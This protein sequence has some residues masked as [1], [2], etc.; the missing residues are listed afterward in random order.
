MNVIIVTVITGAMASILMILPVLL[1]KRKGSGSIYG[2]AGF[3]V[4]VSYIFGH[5]QLTG[6]PPVFEK[7]LNMPT[8]HWTVVIAAVSILP[9]LAVEYAFRGDFLKYFMRSLFIASGLYAVLQIPYIA[10]SWPFWK[11]IAAVGGMSILAAIIWFEGETTVLKGDNRITFPL[12]VT[13]P[14]VSTAVIGLSG[15]FE[16]AILGGLVTA[17]S[18]G[19]VV[20]LL[21]LGLFK[22]EK[23]R[24]F[25]HEAF[26]FAFVMTFFLLVEG[27]FFA[28]VPFFSLVLIMGS[29]LLP[30]LV[31]A[32]ITGEGVDDT[33]SPDPAAGKKIIIVTG[34]VMAL[35]QAGALYIAV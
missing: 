21:V 2:A 20:M 1:Q 14:L 9:V 4:T 30:P 28:Y 23:P 26:S 8:Q 15:T 7:G 12:L 24:V 10:S 18:A 22:F 25:I 34:I 33:G 29:I 27:Y 31:R 16:I 35:A 32:F 13:L 6:M 11:S 19:L 3:I 17:A 5:L